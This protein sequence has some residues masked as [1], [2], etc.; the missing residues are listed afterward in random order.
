MFFGLRIWV[1]FAGKT[2]VSSRHRDAE[3]NINP[4]G[5]IPLIAQIRA[6]QKNPVYQ[7]QG[8]LHG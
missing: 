3:R 1:V 2:R 7:H 4:H 5:T 6:M 8:L